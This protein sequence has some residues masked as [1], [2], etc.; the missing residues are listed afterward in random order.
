MIRR[1]VGWVQHPAPRPHFTFPIVSTA[2]QLIADVTAA[3][4]RFRWRAGAPAG[5][6]RAVPGGEFRQW[7]QAFEGQDFGEDDSRFKSKVAR[8]EMLL[9]LWINDP[10]EHNAKAVMKWVEQMNPSQVA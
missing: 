4:G 5:R 9:L 2:G 7:L 6:L 8:E 3:A 1:G 10:A